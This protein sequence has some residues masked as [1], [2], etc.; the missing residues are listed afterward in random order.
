MNLHC[1][2]S[3]RPPPR[4]GLTALPATVTADG[5]TP[6]DIS[7]TLKDSLGRPS[8]GKLVQINQTGGNSIIGGP[9]PAVTDAS[10]I[11]EFTA[12]DAN[13]ETI[14]YSA[15]DVTD[16]NTPFPETG[17]VTFNDCAGARMLQHGNRGAGIRRGPVCDRIPLTGLRLWRYWLQRMPR[18][19]RDGF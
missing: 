17:T 2:S 13:N 6:A 18:P 4:P 19:V 11:I 1:R 14:T 16:G 8:P 12:V 5:V 3:H 7:V 9:N 15:V 10:G